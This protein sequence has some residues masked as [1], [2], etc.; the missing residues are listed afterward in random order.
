MKYADP[1]VIN[2]RIDAAVEEEMEKVYDFLYEGAPYDLFAGKFAWGD[3]DKEM[4][5]KSSKISWM[6]EATRK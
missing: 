4:K 2:K 6:G 1:I 3:G 5:R